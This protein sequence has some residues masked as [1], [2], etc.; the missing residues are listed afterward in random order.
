MHGIRH[1]LV[2]VGLAKQYD[3]PKKLTDEEIKQMKREFDKFAGK[4]GKL[5]L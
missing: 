4:K 5:I 1:Q 2:K 3:L